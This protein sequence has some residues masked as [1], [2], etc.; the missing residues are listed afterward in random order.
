MAKARSTQKWKDVIKDRKGIKNP[1]FG[2]PHSNDRKKAVSIAV[3]ERIA[4]MTPVEKRLLPKIY[5]R[6]S[7]S[8][9]QAIKVCY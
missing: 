5:Q 3:K 9:G 8:I 1:A 4:N 6:S 2:V 7:N